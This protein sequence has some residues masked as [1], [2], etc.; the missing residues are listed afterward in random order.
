MSDLN[1][2]VAA[3][4]A[5]DVPSRLVPEG[6]SNFIAVVS[7]NGLLG[8]GLFLLLLALGVALHRLNIERTYQRV[9]ATT[10]SGE[11]SRDEL[12]EE[13]FNR[14]GS[15]FNAA[16]VTA[17]M[18]LFAAVAYFY[19][20]TPEIFPRHNYYQIPALS[21]G[22]LGFAIFGFVVFVIT[23]LATAFIPREFYGY[24]EISRMT[25]VVIMLTVPLLMIS[26]ALSVQQGTIFPEVNSVSRILA[27]LALFTS[28]IALLWPIYAEALGGIK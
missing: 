21:S 15:N 18:L 1:G 7:S 10:K 23:G 8:I 28:Q 17:W 2:T 9:V 24:Y 4:Q 6:L 5:V 14:Q 16:A 19:F 20:L 22:P 3:V 26:I 27:F 12:R 25:K 13:M 11:V